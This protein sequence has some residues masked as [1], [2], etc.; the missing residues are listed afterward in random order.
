MSAAQAFAK[1]N[2]ARIVKATPEAVAA[3]DQAWRELL[4]WCGGNVDVA[5]ASA[6][7]AVKA[8]KPKVWRHRV[9]R[10]S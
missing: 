8:A 6:V 7:D 9:R 5:L 4:A 1:A 3:H 2:D 10:S